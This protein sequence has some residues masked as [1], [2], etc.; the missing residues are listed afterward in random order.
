LAKGN[1]FFSKK[2]ST[3]FEASTDEVTEALRRQ[4]TKFKEKQIGR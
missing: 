1:D 3:S 4:L 2:Q